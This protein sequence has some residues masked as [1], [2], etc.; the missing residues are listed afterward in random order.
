MIVIACNG[1]LLFWCLERCQRLEPGC[2]SSEIVPSLLIRLT[3]KFFDFVHVLRVAK[4]LDEGP[5]RDGL[6]VV[7]QWFAKLPALANCD[8][9]GV[10]LIGRRTK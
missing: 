5:H 1:V 4:S 2:R 7:Y 9:D 8:C 10:P 3:A 6:P